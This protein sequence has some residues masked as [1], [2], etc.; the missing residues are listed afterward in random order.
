VLQFKRVRP[1]DAAIIGVAVVVLAIAGWLGYSVWAQNRAVNKSMPASRAVDELIVKLRKNPN[2]IDVRMQL[3]QAL[4]VAGRDREAAEQYKTVLKVRKDYTPALSGIGFI[5]LKQKQWQTGEGYFRRVISLLEGK[6]KP[7][8]DST[9]ETAYFYLG[10]ALMEQKKYEEAIPNLKQAVRYRRD[11]SDTHYALSVAYREVGA[12][13]KSREELEATLLFDPKMPEAN[14]DMGELLLKGGD[15]AGAAER[16]RMSV[17]AA[18]AAE[19]PQKALDALGPFSARMASARKL[20]ASDPGKALIEAR[21]AVAINPRDAGALVL[22]GDLYAATGDKNSAEA[23]YRR[24]LGVAP[25]DISA[26]AGLERV[27]NGK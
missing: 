8:T 25:D 16:F 26:K 1:L 20:E 17:D 15:K 23:N 18:P 21:I 5:Y 6:A 9:L 4:S 7:G 27:T 14:Y 11:A 13:G 3:A 2:D 19:A 10:T 24:A 12:L 22:L